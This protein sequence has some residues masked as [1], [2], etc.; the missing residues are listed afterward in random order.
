MDVLYHIN[1]HE[2][3]NNV[4]KINIDE[5][6]EKKQ[7]HD[8]FTLGSYNKIL[9][10]IHNKIKYT[11]RQYLDNNY[12]WYVIPEVLLGIPKYDHR[13]CISYVIDKLQENN[14]VVRYIHPNLV[15]IS[16]NHW[17]PS[18]VRSE[19]KKKT[20]IVV[21]GNGKKLNDNN[22]KNSSILKNENDNIIFNVNKSNKE[23]VSKDLKK[24]STYYKDIN[25]YKPQGK[26]IYNDELLKKLTLND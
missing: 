12:C 6:Y 13:E 8:M 2:D 17:I 19:L 18:Y 10:R 3:D 4:S 24:N 16:W 20:G 9:S 7:Q 5:L 14:F 23:I 11:S 15:F 26:F 25:T 22:N 21:D 1:R